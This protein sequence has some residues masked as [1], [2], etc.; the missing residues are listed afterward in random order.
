MPPTQRCGAWRN[1]GGARR[2]TVRVAES[3]LL[4]VTKIVGK[5]ERVKGI[6]PSS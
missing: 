2:R 1:V 5:L 4:S 6:E 3:A